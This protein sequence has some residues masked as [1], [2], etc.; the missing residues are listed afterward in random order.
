MNDTSDKYINYHSQHHFSQKVAIIYNL[1]DK[2]IILSDKSFH[3]QNISIIKSFFRTNDFPLH[4]INKYIDKRLA[5]IN[6]K[7]ISKNNDTSHNSTRHCKNRDATYVNLT[8]RPLKHREKEQACCIKN[9][10]ENRLLQF[11]ILTQN[12]T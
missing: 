4:I 9:K 3:N 11:N 8:T 10:D 6:S 1:V 7:P 12:T 2:A 5:H